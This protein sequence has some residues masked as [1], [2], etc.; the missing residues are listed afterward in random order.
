MFRTHLVFTR[1][2]ALYWCTRDKFDGTYVYIHTYIHTYTHTP[3]YIYIEP[4]PLVVSFSN[5]AV[6]CSMLQHVAVCCSRPHLW[7]QFQKLKGPARRIRWH[8]SLNKDLGHIPLKMLHPQNP[9]NPETQILRKR[10]KLKRNYSLDLYREIPRNPS[11]SRF[12]AFWECSILSGK[13]DTR[14]TLE[15]TNG[16]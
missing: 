8:L 12:G 16:V 7:C 3:M 15:V 13:C 6:C 1:H 4:T 2:L 14:L 9:P 5:V 11:F 10:I